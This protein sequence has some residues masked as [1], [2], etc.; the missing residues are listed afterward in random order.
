M[1]KFGLPSGRI[2]KLA[3]HDQAGYV[4]KPEPHAL[5]NIGENDRGDLK[6]D[7]PAA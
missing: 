2:P 3:L 1:H 7:C 6:R 4:A 5:W